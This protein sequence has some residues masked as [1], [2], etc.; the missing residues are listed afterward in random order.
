M[1]TMITNMS[2]D[3]NNRFT[4]MSTRFTDMNNRFTDMNTRFTDMNTDLMNR[5]DNIDNRLYNSTASDNNSILRPPMHN[6]IVPPN[7]FPRTVRALKAL[8]DN[9][10]VEVETFYGL[11]LI[12][13]TC[14]FKQ[15]QD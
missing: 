1:N 14:W 9:L 7:H 12:I 15:D 8:N 4:D 3:M 10:L 6:N 5:V 2:S 13:T 11:H